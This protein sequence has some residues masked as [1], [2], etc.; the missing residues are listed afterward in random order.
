MGHDIYAYAGDPDADDDGGGVEVSYLRRNAGDPY[1]VVI[2]QV[3]DAQEAFGATGSS[4]TG[5]TFPFTRE[6]VEQAMERLRLFFPGRDTEREESF[7]KDILAKMDET[8]WILF[9]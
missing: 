4:G 9:G 2:Y 3:L 5:E 6:E 8:C 7:L 1:K